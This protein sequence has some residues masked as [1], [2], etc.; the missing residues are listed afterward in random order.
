M[1]GSEVL[2]RCALALLA[3]AQTAPS[4]TFVYEAVAPGRF[5]HR[6]TFLVDPD[7]AAA[8]YAA[9]PWSRVIGSRTFYRRSGT[10]ELEEAGDAEGFVPFLAAHF[11]EL[12]PG[13][14]GTPSAECTPIVAYSYSGCTPQGGCEGFCG[15]L[16]FALHAFCNGVCSGETTCTRTSAQVLSVSLGTFLCACVAQPFP[17]PPRICQQGGSPP[18]V[19][20]TSSGP[21]C[22]CQPPGCLSMGPGWNGTSPPLLCRTA[23]RVGSDFRLE[24]ANNTAQA[25]G[26][27]LLGPCFSPPLA[28]QAT[29]LCNGGQILWPVPLHLVALPATAPFEWVLSIPAEPSL[30]GAAL[31]V[32]GWTSDT[33]GN[34]I[35]ATDGVQVTILP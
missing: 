17:F 26:V 18:I 2:L 35:R 20:F 11:P 32:Q 13:A 30:A 27:L 25:P 29:P 33:R 10:G 16:G 21:L 9:H 22:H 7:V 5:E 12:G 3:P 34:C 8:A 4:L 28:L 6:R 31:C 15:A 1:T 19:S 23:P 14:A 24:V